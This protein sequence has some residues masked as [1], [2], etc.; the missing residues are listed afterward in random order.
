MV[1]INHVSP[2]LSAVLPCFHWEVEG[3]FCLQPG[4]IFFV[5]LLKERGKRFHIPFM[6]KDCPIYIIWASFWHLIVCTN[7][8]TK[9]Y[10]GIFRFISSNAAVCHSAS[11]KWLFIFL[12]ELNITP[13]LSNRNNKTEIFKWLIQD[14]TSR[15]LCQTETWVLI[16]H[17]K[18]KTILLP[19]SEGK[20]YNI[21]APE[22]RT[23][24]GKDLVCSLPAGRAIVRPVICHLWC[25]SNNSHP[26][27]SILHTLQLASH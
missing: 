1:L 24:S 6:L 18:H 25:R 3:L 22:L 16:Q 23:S 9:C 7:T 17:L 13:H 20:Y 5:D 2:F 14:D 10:L 26:H 27:P 19:L 11:L 12:G 21:S 8:N 15:G 4:R